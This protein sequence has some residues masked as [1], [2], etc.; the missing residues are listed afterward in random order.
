MNDNTMYQTDFFIDTDGAGETIT[1]T[2][3]APYTLTGSFDTDTISIDNVTTAYDNV[4]M[5]R[6]LVVGDTEISESQVKD[7]LVL[8]DII[9]ELDD[10]NPIKEMFNCKKMLDKIK[11][12][13]NANT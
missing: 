10:D 11:G 5:R 12:D 7:L 9:G 3:D 2:N 13:A 1:I 8:L 6:P 4:D